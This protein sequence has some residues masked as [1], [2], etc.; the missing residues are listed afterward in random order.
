[1]NRVATRFAKI[2]SG[3]ALA[4]ALAGCTA[5][6]PDVFF[7]GD[8]K[9]VK[10]APL[11]WCQGDTKTGFSDCVTEKANR[12]QLRLA[13]GEPVLVELPTDV[14]ATPWQ[15]YA[16]YVDSAGKPGEVRS[17]LFS[18]GKLTYTLRPPGAGSQLTYVELQALPVPVQ[19]IN[20]NPNSGGGIDFAFT[21]TWG[22]VIE[23]TV[24]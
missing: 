10:A 5:P 1:M 9:V 3:V 15:V 19:N 12:V 7:Y 24:G 20:S 11:F 17:T 2:G 22:A 8:Q 13:P 18:D 16:R 21:R 6:R 23:S 14:A 4:L